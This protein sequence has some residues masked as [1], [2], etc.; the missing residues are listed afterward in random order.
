MANKTLLTTFAK[1]FSVE[2]FYFSPVTV[3]PPYL[4]I[5]LASLYCFLSKVDP[6]DDEDNPP[7]PQNIQ[8]Y[9]CC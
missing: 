9:V 2:Q 8:K 7:V 1:Q 4:N 5:P 6:W 3:V